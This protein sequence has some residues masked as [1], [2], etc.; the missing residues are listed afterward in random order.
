VPDHI[1]SSLIGASL[2][3]PVEDGKLKLGA[4]QEV[5]LIEFNGPRER[6]IIVSFEPDSVAANT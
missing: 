4:W 1:L 2:T 5:V 3:V 6:E